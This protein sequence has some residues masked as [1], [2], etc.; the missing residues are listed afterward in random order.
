MAKTTKSVAAMIANQEM[1]MDYISDIMRVKRDVPI[2]YQANHVSSRSEDYWIGLA[3][4][5]NSMLEY[6]MHKANCY[7]GFSYMGEPKKVPDGTMSS[8]ST[9]PG[10]A[11]YAGWRRMY[12]TKG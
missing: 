4:G 7:A 10:N 2:E 12:Y 8:Q 5:V 11:D 6:A 3:D 9:R 1:M